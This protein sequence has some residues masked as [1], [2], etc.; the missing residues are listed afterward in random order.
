VQKVFIT[1]GTGSLGN[2]FL[3]RAEALKWQATVFSRDEVKQAEL[4]SKYPDHRFVL[5]DI[6]DA[7]WLKRAMRGHDVVIHAAAYKQVPAA[8]VNSGQ[9]AEVN[10]I[11]SLNVATAAVD[12]NIQKVIGI[13]TDKAC[14]PVNCYGATK[15][16][17]EKI[18]QEACNWGDTKFNLVRYGN[19]LGSR[20]SVVPLFQHQSKVLQMITLTNPRMTRFWLT[21]DQAVDLVV[22]AL[23]ERQ[24]G[25][26]LIPKCPASTMLVL[27]QAVAPHLVNNLKYKV[28]GVRP[29]EKTHEQLLHSGESMHTDDIETHFRV[30]PA[31]TNYVGN[32][33]DGFEYTSATAHQLSV[34]ELQQ[35]IG[36]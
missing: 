28:I 31:F 19:V 18:F 25:T 7:N 17:M 6:R 21:L 22:C 14:A 30:Y 15:M 16:V 13:S 11:G 5:G 4:K 10:V 29:G 1:G 9:A 33:P 32:L 20:G 8:E 35:M 12:T 26:V 3:K 24:A 27:A 23:A 36:L 2:A 34:S